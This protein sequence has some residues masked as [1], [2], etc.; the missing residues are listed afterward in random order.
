MDVSGQIDT[1]EAKGLIRV[2]ALRPELEYLFRHWLIQDAAYESL[3]K[4]ERREL[5]RRVGEA[6]ESLYADR[7]NELA[8]VLAWHFE[9]AGEIDKAV[10]YLLADGRYAL[11]RA[12]IQ[13]AHAAFD[14]AVRL[15][16]PPA[17][18]EPDELRRRRIEIEVDRARAGW[19]FR[20]PAE[21]IDD[22]E[23][24][25]PLAEQLGDLEL[26]AQAHLHLALVLIENGEPSDDP[27]VKRSLD[28]LAEISATLEDPSL[29]A[30][31]LALRAMNKVLTGPVREG[32]EGLEGAV[33]L[34]QSRRDFIGAAFARGWL[35]IG[36]ATLGEFAKAD[37]AAREATE[38]AASGDLVAQLDAQISEAMV[39]SAQGELDKAVPLA[40][41][42][43]QR[44]EETGATA[45]AVVSAW[46]LGDAYQRQARYDEAAQVLQLGL[47]LSRGSP[48]GMWGP[49]LSA[50]LRANP[51]PFG[52]VDPD[53]PEWAS[54]LEK[55]RGQRNRMGEAAIISK[56]AEAAAQRE[57]WDVAARDFG[58]G[59]AIYE[60]QGA[61][62]NLARVLRGWA[63]ALLAGG[64]PDAAAQKLRESLALFEAMGLER[65]ATEV[66]G[67]LDAV[68]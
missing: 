15:L 53:A 58:A 11:E 54:V 19:T 59:A 13:E 60:E 30:L 31:P 28:R 4:Q 50:W 46:V 47:D 10:T 49:T 38:L 57:R 55:V 36:Y 51:M 9:Q 24:I 35:A 43:V 40:Q 52:D 26:L 22:L 68:R 48:M 33:P 37:A 65:E 62:P 41:A 6:I 45:C 25:F 61:R 12:A 2:A 20:P 44:S 39:R 64:Q 67:E 14:A 1:L 5:H 18:D 42:C 34:M 27:A 8:G 66:R 56:R 7:Q 21:V 23:R 17:P 29:A 63:R 3:L 16:P 32:V